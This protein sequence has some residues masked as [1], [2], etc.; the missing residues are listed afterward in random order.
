MICTDSSWVATAY[1]TNYAGATPVFV[2]VAPDT[3]CLDPDAV[4]RAIT[5]RT[6]A[7]MP[8]HCFAHPADMDALM[9]IAHEHGLRVI[10]DAA[11]ARGP[12]YKGK[13]VGRFGDVACFSFQGA[14][15]AASGEGG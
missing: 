10:E 12:L 5:S 13:K 8:A 7:I 6:K 11:P 15:I 3:S 9:A 2:D 1:A 4:R 14:K